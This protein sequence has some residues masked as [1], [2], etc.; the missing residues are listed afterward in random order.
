MQP[1]EL[2]AWHMARALELAARGR[3]WVEPNPLVGCVVT[4]GAEIIGEGWHRRY[5]QA[6]AEIEALAITGSRAEGATLYVTLEPCCHF[7]KTPP[8]TA[9]IVAAGV[10]RVV[11]AMRDPFPVVA[12]QGLA[13]LKSAGIEVEVGLLE[14]EARRLNAPYLKLLASGR[15][16]VIAKWAM[17]V[18]GKLASRT[19]DSRWISGEAS[20]RIVHELRGR[21]DAIVI[22]RGTAQA[23]DPLLTA[24]PPGA[25]LATR[26]VLDSR[27]ALSSQSQLVQTARDVPLLVAA[28]AAAAAADYQRLRSAGCE[29]LIFDGDT[30]AQRLDQ[31]LLELGRRRLTN[32]LV[33][34]GGQL[35]GSL[36]DAKQIDEVHAFIAPKL[37]GGSGAIVPFG[38]T[39]L[40]AMAQ[41][42]SLED[43]QW[44][45]VDGDLY[46]HATTRWQA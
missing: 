21:A 33:E 14:A 43:A 42:V 6:H 18:D 7:G 27:A 4:R 13:E 41:A 23:D 22:G 30:P 5:G 17:T 24:R 1:R 45:S 12:G 40:E 29:V 16:W 26:I 10:R 37:L 36:L 28:G 44:Q 8:C 2:D 35:L 31:L 20:R 19:G 25:R 38:G 32:V 34:G 15:P 3:G 39:G 46:L 9:A 11:A